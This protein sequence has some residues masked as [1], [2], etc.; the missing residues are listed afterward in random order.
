VLAFRPVALHWLLAASASCVD[1]FRRCAV[2]AAQ[3]EKLDRHERHCAQGLGRQVPTAWQVPAPAWQVHSSWPA[4]K[5]HTPPSGQDVVLLQVPFGSPASKQP[6][7]AHTAAEQQKPSSW[8]LL[9]ATG[10]A[11][12]HSG[13]SMAQCADECSTAVPVRLRRAPP[14]QNKPGCVCR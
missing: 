13:G 1:S 5:S 14:V 7:Q 2:M 8:L 12:L 9:A 10:G 11:A 6:Q 3:P 4:D